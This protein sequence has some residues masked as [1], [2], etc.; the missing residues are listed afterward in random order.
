M[1]RLFDFWSLSL[2]REIN[3]VISWKSVLWSTVCHVHDMMTPWC[4][5]STFWPSNGLHVT[6]AMKQPVDQI[7]TFHVISML[8][9]KSWP[10]RDGQKSADLRS[11]GLNAYHLFFHVSISVA[12]A[13]FVRRFFQRLQHTSCLSTMWLLWPP[14]HTSSCYFGQW[15]INTWS[16]WFTV[17]FGDYFIQTTRSITQQFHHDG[18]QLLFTCTATTKHWH[19]Y[20]ACSTCTHWWPSSHTGHQK[21]HLNIHRLRIY[22]QAFPSNQSLWTLICDM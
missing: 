8:N 6:V 4:L 19:A 9:Y 21:T 2:L 14:E 12:C 20:Y 13:K 1:Y 3:I 15:K 10:H 22:I 11:P 7:W 18:P 5:S 17:I 16:L